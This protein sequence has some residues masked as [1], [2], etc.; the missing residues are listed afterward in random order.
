MTTGDAAPGPEPINFVKALSTLPELCLAKDQ[1][2]LAKDQRRSKNGA[3]HRFFGCVA[4]CLVCT[5]SDPKCVDDS[6]SIRGCF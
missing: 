6:V 4:A 2:C 5:G 1:L 3:V